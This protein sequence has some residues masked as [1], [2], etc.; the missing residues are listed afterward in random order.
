MSFEPIPCPTRQ[1]KGCTPIVMYGSGD[2]VHSTSCSTPAVTRAR[3][4]TVRKDRLALERM[5]DTYAST[6]GAE[7]YAVYPW[8][9]DRIAD[10]HL[11][12]A[13]TRVRAKFESEAALFLAGQVEHL[14]PYEHEQHFRKLVHRSQM[15]AIW[16]PDRRLY[17]NE[18][19]KDPETDLVCPAMGI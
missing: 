11:R 2:V 5:L 19:Q 13:R 18:P 16:D 15:A 7:Q 14:S 17:P 3:E 8:R 12:F 10:K 6:L 4:S 9:G 1:C